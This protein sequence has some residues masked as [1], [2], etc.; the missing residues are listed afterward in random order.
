MI[1]EELALVPVTEAIKYAGSKL[2][3]IPRILELIRFTGVQSVFDGFSGSTRISQ[4]LAQSGFRVLSN[5]RADWSRVLGVCYLLNQKPAESYQK[6]IDHLNSMAPEE[7]WFTEHYGGLVS[8]GSAGSAVQEDGSKK[9]WQRKNTRKL[10]AIRREIDRLDLDEVSRCVALT[11]LILALDQ[12]DNSLG[13]HVSY[14]KDWSPRSYNDLSLKVPR[15]W[16]NKTKHQVIQ[17]DV[18]NV[19]SEVDAE[20]A[21]Y[22]PPYG[23]NNEKMPPSRV[24]YS[25]YYH[26]WTTVC[27]NDQPE[28][29]GKANRRA[30]TSD[31][32]SC[33]VFEEFRR[34][35][36][37]RLIAV[38]AI[39][40]LLRCTACPWVLLSYSSGGRATAE[41][42]NQVI[43]SS[44]DLIQVIEIDYQKNVMASMRWTQE[45]LKEAEEPHREFLFLIKK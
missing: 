11:S 14:L 24:R 4:A 28:I 19:A 40:N 44:G 7:G 22:D 3:L 26:L 2:K 10:D 13:H 15:I 12:V 31:R 27:R 23:S 18:F 25:S 9:P 43:T 6:L 5:D 1:Q 32:V 36:E 20:L 41:E 30:D 35:P 17:E 8:S 38:E 42:L 33:S 21:Y 34:N 37:G 39:D 45:W 29:F 16:V